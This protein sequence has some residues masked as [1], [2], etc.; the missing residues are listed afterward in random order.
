MNLFEELESIKAKGFIVCIGINV[1]SPNDS[2]R[3]IPCLVMMA[4][5]TEGDP[6]VDIESMEGETVE[7]TVL[8]AITVFD[9]EFSE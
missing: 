9:A 6:E 2:E 4:N 1:P 5:D 7:Q 8:R 3:I